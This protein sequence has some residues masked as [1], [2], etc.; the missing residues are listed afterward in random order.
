[1]L[2]YNRILNN[3]LSKPRYSW[4]WKRKLLI[5]SGYQGVKEGKGD[6]IM[7]MEKNLTLGGKHTMQYT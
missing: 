3:L 7:V 5:I 1:M 2:L 4:E 6:P